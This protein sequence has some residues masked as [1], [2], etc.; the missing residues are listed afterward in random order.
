MQVRRFEAL[1]SWRGLCACMV[2]LFHFNVFSHVQSARIIQNAYLF[3]DFF[4]VLSGFVIAANYQARLMQGFGSGRFL[5]LRLGRIYPLH[6]AT[7]ALFIPIDIAKDG[8][9]LQLLRAVATNALLLH[10]TGINSGLWLNFPS[11][12]ISAEFVAYIVFAL[13]TSWLGPRMLPWIAIAMAGSAILV[14]VSP[15]RMDSTYDYGL[16]RCLY[17]FALGVLCFRVRERFHWLDRPIG[18][19][20]DT[21]AEGI[22]VILLYLCLAMLDGHSA[23]AVATPALFAGLV[24]LFARERGLVSRALKVRPLLLVGALSYSI[25]MMHAFVRAVARALAMVLEK[26][27]GLSFFMELPALANGEIP[28]LLSIGGSLWLGDVLQALMLLATIGLAMLTFRY[29]E[30]P[31]RLWSRSAHPFIRHREGKAI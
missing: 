9:S 21:L 5:F 10:G 27:T 8:A 19:H 17:G 23:A 4:F 13:A 15:H 29:I 25:Y 3:V 28:R 12:S 22:A 14:F 11:W 16:A 30:E 24:L 7:M 31:G 20:A 1:D 2:A 6:L 26:T 18:R